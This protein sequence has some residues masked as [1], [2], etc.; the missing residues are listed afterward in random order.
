VG[1]VGD[2]AFLMT[3][4]EMLTATEHGLGIV[5][6][7]FNDGELSQISQAQALPYNRKACT[8]LP[9]VRIQGIADAVGA[10]YFA[11]TTDA[12]IERVIAEA[13]GAAQ[14][15][16]PVVVDVRID[17]SKKTRFTQGI[18][19]TNLGR[20]GLTDKLRMVGRAAWRRVQPPD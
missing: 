18:V 11:M 13:D 6:Y 15:G 1:I 10:A 7:V 14:A 3:G 4:L 17:Y 8:V 19:K 20:M 12:D 2:G 9:E 16:R 5:Y